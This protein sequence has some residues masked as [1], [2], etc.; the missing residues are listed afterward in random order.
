[1]GTDPTV[2][3]ADEAAEVSDRAIDAATASVPPRPRRRSMSAGEGLRARPRRDDP[4]D[5]I[6]GLT[7]PLRDVSGAQAASVPVLADARLRRRPQG[8]RSAGLQAR[9]QAV[10]WHDTPIAVKPQHAAD[11]EAQQR[12][13]RPGEGDAPIRPP[14]GERRGSSTSW[15]RDS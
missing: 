6:V 5:R 15:N 4:A 10:A 13:R 1:M 11:D 14:F 7:L 8:G 3:G 12:R 2:A 9:A